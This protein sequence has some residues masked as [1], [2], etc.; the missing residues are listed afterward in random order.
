MEARWFILPDIFLLSM[1]LC[2]LKSHAHEKVSCNPMNNAHCLVENLKS[3]SHDAQWLQDNYQN[4]Q[5]KR[6][7]TEYNIH[8]QT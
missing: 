4:N 1:M 5:K 8:K 7:H 2:E 3:D 6:E